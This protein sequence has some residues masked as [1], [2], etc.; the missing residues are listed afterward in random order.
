MRRAVFLDRDGVLNRAIVRE[1][2][3]YPPTGLAELEILPGVVEACRALREAGFVLV[4]VSNQP[5]VRRGTQQRETVE[6]IN[7][8][9]R[10]HVPVDDIRVCYHDDQDACICRKP[11]PGL[12][13]EAA[14][15]WE[16]DLRASFMVGDRWKDVEAGRRA[17][18]KT[19]LVDY[20]Y[21]ERPESAPDCRV[22][23]LAEAA[24]WILRH[25]FVAMNEETHEGSR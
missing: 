1:G 4:A 8:A 20:G 14:K 9:L 10:A 24:R 6:A 25:D 3:P 17:G 16:I 18:C 7:R 2:K 12:L 11:S 15:Q 13:L 22:R 5:D 19:I 21:S 23:S